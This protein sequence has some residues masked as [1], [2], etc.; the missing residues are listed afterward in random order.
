MSSSYPLYSTAGVYPTR[1]HK[2]VIF[3]TRNG[4]RTQH[5]DL[6]LGWPQG[7]FT[8][9][10]NKI[11]S[12]QLQRLADLA[13]LT[14]T[15]LNRPH[16]FSLNFQDHFSNYGIFFQSYQG[17]RQDKTE[18]MPFLQSCSEPLLF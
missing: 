15:T 8:M 5:S 7:S 6:V 2:T 13:S 4:R 11:Q 18:Q 16:V 12:R 3:E 1:V 9:R 10:M 17:Q 14:M